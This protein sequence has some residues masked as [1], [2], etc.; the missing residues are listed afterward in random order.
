MHEASPHGGG[1]S[2]DSDSTATGDD[3]GDSDEGTG[4]RVGGVSPPPLVDDASCDV[5]SV[6]I[7]D[8]DD[9]EVNDAELSG[10]KRSDMFAGPVPT[11]PRVRRRRSAASA[12]GRSP[13]ARVQAYRDANEELQL[14]L[15][16]QQALMQHAAARLK[17]AT[18]WHEVA[19]ATRLLEF[20]PPAAPSG[21]CPSPV[22]PASPHSRKRSRAAGG[23]PG[24]G[25]ARGFAK[26]QRPQV[27]QRA[28]AEREV[29]GSSSDDDEVVE[30]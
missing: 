17:A 23:T 26:K 12:D 19:V 4:V 1:G 18:T 27:Q 13:T 3:R 6:G 7:H 11:R 8:V 15:E 5:I 24:E 25:M 30:V 9:A 22:H 29:E 28:V 16:A 14:Q 10:V 20:Q 2:A 21:S